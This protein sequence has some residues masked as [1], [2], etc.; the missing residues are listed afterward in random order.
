[1]MDEPTSSLDILAAETVEKCLRE[2]A[3]DYPVIMVT[4]SLAQAWRLSDQFYCFHRGR[5]ISPLRCHEIET[6]RELMEFLLS[7]DQ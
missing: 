1:M 5:Y 2:L 4:H 7:L 3:E 6:E